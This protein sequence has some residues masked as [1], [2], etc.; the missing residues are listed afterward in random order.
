MEANETADLRCRKCRPPRIST[1]GILW[2]AGPR[3]RALLARLSEAEND[4]DGPLPWWVS[5]RWI[6][7]WC[8]SDG[9]PI[10]DDRGLRAAYRQLLD[11]FLAGSFR[12]IR[13][14][15]LGDPASARWSEPPALSNAGGI[16]GYRMTAQFLEART[17]IYSPNDP[18]QSWI[19]F[20]GYLAPCW[21]RRLAAARWL[22]NNRYPLPSQWMTPCGLADASRE[23]PTPKTQKPG[24][25]RE[26][27]ERERVIDLMRRKMEDGVGIGGLRRN[28]HSWASEFKTTPSTAY[29]AAVELER[30]LKSEAELAAS[31]ALGCSQSPDQERPENVSD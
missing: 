17:K 21:I 6:A 14:L 3:I 9:S 24:L 25:R 8:S 28:K 30:R 26:A 16:A 5:F 29:E 7:S 19:L 20:N 18:D 1:P 2:M 27:P 31:V 22:E 12:T 23:Q 11:S 10:V 4:V 13:V 15:Y